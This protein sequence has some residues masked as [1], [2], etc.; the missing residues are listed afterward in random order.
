MMK[1]RKM[2]FKKA[3]ACLAALGI[4][5]TTAM[6]SQAIDDDIPFSLDLKANQEE[7]YTESRY[8]ETTNIQNKWKVNVLVSTEGNGKVATFWL[9]KDDAGKSGVSNKQNIAQGT[10]AHYYNAHNGASKS[11][12]SLAVENNNYTSNSYDIAG[13]WD[14]ETD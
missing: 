2:S 1:N 5:G 12:V 4:I 7:S 10:G 13:F 6:T 3:A 14:E 8:R 11:Y 9:A